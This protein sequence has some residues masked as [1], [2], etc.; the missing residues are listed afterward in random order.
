MILCPKGDLICTLMFQRGIN[1]KGDLIY[2]LTYKRGLNLCFD[3]QKETGD[4]N[5]ALMSKRGLNL[6]QNRHIFFPFVAKGVLN[7]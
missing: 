5:C 7:L 6:C 4:L 1:V 3:I 2:A